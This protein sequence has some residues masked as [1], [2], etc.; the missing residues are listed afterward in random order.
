[1]GGFYSIKEC[2]DKKMQFDG[3]LIIEQGIEFAI[4]VTGKDVTDN[5]NYALSQIEAF[6]EIFP[7]IPVILMS[8]DWRGIA[9]FYG[10]G[11]IVKF[12]S[13]IPLD[14]IPWKKF[15]LD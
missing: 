11:D 15:T 12:L 9:S 14:T 13:K 7:D 8:Q 10:R 6:G 5:P 1:M 3:A 4:V 2:Q